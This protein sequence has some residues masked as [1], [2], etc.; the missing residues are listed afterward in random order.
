MHY[1]ERLW[2]T[3]TTSGARP[4]SGPMSYGFGMATRGEPSTYPPTWKRPRQW[5]FPDGSLW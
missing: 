2:I 1:Q 4:P 3:K 5:E